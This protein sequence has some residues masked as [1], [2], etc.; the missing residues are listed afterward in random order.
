VH[1]TFHFWSGDTVEYT[2]TKEG[3][4]VTGTVG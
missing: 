2:V 3:D 1:L 4:T